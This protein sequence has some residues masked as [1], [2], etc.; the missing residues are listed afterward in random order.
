MPFF[1]PSHCLVPPTYED[2]WQ[3]D[4]ATNDRF[5]WIF[6]TF[7]H[8]ANIL[9]T[10]QWYVQ[11]SSRENFCF[12]AGNRTCWFVSKWSLSANWFFVGNVSSWYFGQRAKTRHLGDKAKESSK[13]PNF[14]AKM[15]LGENFLCMYCA[16]LILRRS[17]CAKSRRW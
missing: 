1:S 12:S 11:L 4:V 9:P 6:T 14:M 16:P 3:I 2:F 10:C 5:W 15:L 8:F 13:M 7:W 17:K